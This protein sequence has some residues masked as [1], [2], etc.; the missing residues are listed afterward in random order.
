MARNSKCKIQKEGRRQ[1]TEKIFMATVTIHQRALQFSIT[2]AHFLQ[3]VTL[4]PESRAVRSQVMRSGCS[5]GA[6]IVEA[7]HGA[8]KKEFRRYMSIALRSARETEYWLTVLGSLSGIKHSQIKNIAMENDELSK[9][10]ATII[11]KSKE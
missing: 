1:G 2:L 10:I 7:Q 11:L 9:I 8:T 6:N 4:T 5:I 3:S